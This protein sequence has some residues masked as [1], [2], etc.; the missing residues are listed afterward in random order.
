MSRKWLSNEIWPCYDKDWEISKF[1]KIS[2]FKNKYIIS[3][4]G[5]AFISNLYMLE[6]L[7]Y[8]GR[9]RSKHL[10][11]ELNTLLFLQHYAVA[12]DE[13][14][15]THYLD[16]QLPCWQFSCSWWPHSHQVNLCFEV[17]LLTL[18]YLFIA[19]D[20]HCN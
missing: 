10:I 6:V 5:I 3:S 9:V 4:S 18:K 15:I 14:M 1:K 19:W 17:V 7:A 13:D 16:S 2:T 11:L 20:D 8:Y 12:T